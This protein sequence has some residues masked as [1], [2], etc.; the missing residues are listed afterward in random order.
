MAEAVD[1][2]VEEMLESAGVTF[3]VR[4]H[5]PIQNAADAARET[6][7]PLEETIKTLAFRIAPDRIVLAAF[8]GHRRLQYGQL[9]RALGVSRSWLRPAAPEDVARLGMEPGG[10]A[11]VCTD[12]GVRIVFDSTVQA[13]GEVY[14]GSGRSDRTLVVHARD[15]LRLADAPV[16]ADITAAE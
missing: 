16:L 14:C 3:S 13:M 8:P 12:N 6:T 2:T 7:Y 11:P 9:A 1:V 4:N 10:V 5:R 15:L